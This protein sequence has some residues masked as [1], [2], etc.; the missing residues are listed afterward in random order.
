MA[1]L[2]SIIAFSK[3]LSSCSDLP[4]SY[5]YLFCVPSLADFFLV[6]REIASKEGCFATKL[7]L[8]SHH[9]SGCWCCLWGD[10]IIALAVSSLSFK[11][12]VFLVRGYDGLNAMVLLFDL[13][14]LIVLRFDPPVFR[15]LVR[16]IDCLLL[17]PSVL[18]SSSFLL[19]RENSEFRI[20]SFLLGAVSS[21]KFVE[22]PS[23]RC[24]GV[25]SRSWAGC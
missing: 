16:L 8:L 23:L 25:S 19:A 4:R 10:C 1:N 20:F 18:T 7:T 22:S 15:V 13:M 12:T 17:S 11:V 2:I 24:S 5:Y 9:S 3:S 6:S 14:T 21:S